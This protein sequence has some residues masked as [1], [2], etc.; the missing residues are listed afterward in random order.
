MILTWNPEFLCL[1]TFKNFG[2]NNIILLETELSESNYFVYRLF[3]Y[4]TL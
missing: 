1:K 2:P 4:K 3:I